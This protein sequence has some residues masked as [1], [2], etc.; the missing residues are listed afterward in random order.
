MAAAVAAEIGADRTAIRL[1]P[2]SKLGGIDEGSEGHDLYREL[3]AGLDK[4]GL[5]YL[6]VM[7]QGNV[8]LLRDLRAAW[9][10]I[11]ILNRPGRPQ[12][13][14]GAD[15]ATGLCDLEAY[16]QLV[17]ANPDFVARLQADAL[18][19]QHNPQTYYGGA[20]AGY[21]DYPTMENSAAK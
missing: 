10:G 14:I 15:V 2:G 20:E 11:L 18:M 9:N 4:L 1:S 21:T 13:A 16:G 12:D 5:A 8:E 3:V 7:D 6:H 17:L 19:N